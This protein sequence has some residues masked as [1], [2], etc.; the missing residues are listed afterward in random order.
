MNLLTLLA[1]T[2][3][4]P[5][6]GTSTEGALTDRAYV[7][8]ETSNE[9]FV[10]D[11]KTLAE[12]GTVDTT[13]EAG[14]V[15]GNHMAMVTGDG[16]KVYVSASETNRLV[17]FDAA[18]LGRI[19]T[20]PVGRHNTHVAVREGTNELWV[21]NEDDDTI[22]V[23]DTETD[24]V[25]RT[26][27]DPSFATPHFARFSEGYAYVPNIAGN[28]ISVVDLATYAVV[29]TLVPNGLTEG[30]CESDPCGF[31]D[32]QISP[33]G[34]LYASHFASG[35]VLV[36]DTIAHVRL[37]DA[38]AG[39]QTWS[40]FVDP[41]SERDEALVPSW[42]TESVARVGRDGATSLWS[43]G[44]AEVYGVNFSPTAPD[45]V[46]VLNRVRNE[47]AVVDRTTGERVDTLAAGGTTETATTTPDGRLLLP[48]SSTGEVVVYD[49]ATREEL[50]RFSGVGDHPWSVATAAGQN[51]CH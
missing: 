43:A 34:V 16:A 51:Y 44:D 48:V 4:V 28:H 41:F 27:S 3:A 12:I 45:L 10:F 13:V 35:K 31:A 33:S 25:V 9:L 32:A 38:E 11:A 42:L 14:L 7:V 22:S 18:T 19:G 17:V 30:T 6:D 40:A 21:M 29:D 46:F 2:A 47:V 26:L 5:T 20:I 24:T 49:T 37:A 8:S 15:N 50:A 39:G 36:Y 23:V 1:C